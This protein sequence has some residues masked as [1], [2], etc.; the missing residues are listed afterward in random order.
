LAASENRWR[1]GRN[2][3]SGI[4][5]FAAAVAAAGA[6]IGFVLTEGRVRRTRPGARDAALAP[7]GEAASALDA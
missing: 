2:P 7:G 4:P 6:V 3:V 1:L 5:L